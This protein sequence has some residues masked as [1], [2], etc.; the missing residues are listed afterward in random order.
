MNPSLDWLLRE[1]ANS[2]L[3]V[4]VLELFLTHPD[5]SLSTFELAFRLNVSTSEIQEV[6]LELAAA[7]ALSYF[8]TSDQCSLEWTE[9]NEKVVQGYE[10]LSVALRETPESVWNFAWPAP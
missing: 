3:K 1:V 7:Q 5:L 8:A 2:A 9:I 10:A 4:R 6:V